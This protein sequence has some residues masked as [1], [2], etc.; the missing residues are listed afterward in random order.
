LY[1]SRMSYILE[2]LEFPFLVTVNVS[3]GNCYLLPIKYIFN[4]VEKSRDKTYV[5]DKI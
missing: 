2:Q 4:I 3:F 1:D 5:L